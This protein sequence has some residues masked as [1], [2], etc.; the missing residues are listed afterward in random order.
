M[1]DNVG[2]RDR[3][4]A[5]VDIAAI[6]LG[7]GVKIQRVVAQGADAHDAA[8][9]GNP[10]KVGGRARTALPAAVAQD[11]RVDSIHDRFGR[12][13]SLVAPLEQR[14]GGTT[15]FR[16]DTASDVIAAPGSN[17][18]IVVTSIAVVNSHA[19]VGTKVSIRDA[20]TAKVGP[21]GAGPNYGGFVITDPNGLFVAT[22]NR[23][24]TAICATT[25]A[26]VDVAVHGYLIPA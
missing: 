26:D 22:A 3:D 9:S 24:V 13:L 8:D 16:A 7:G 11:D 21:L 10:I 23:A 1:A 19:T 18:A 15:N 5:N 6:D 14:V 12:S 2:I 25:G 4:G 20:T 17:L